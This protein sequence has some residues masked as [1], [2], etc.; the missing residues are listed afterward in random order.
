MSYEKMMKRT[1]GHHHDKDY[2]PM[3]F[4]MN[5]NHIESRKSIAER[6]ADTFHVRVR[7]HSHEE[8]V[9]ISHD[10]LTEDDA[11][12]YCMDNDLDRQYG[13]VRIYTDKGIHL[14]GW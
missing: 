12:Q 5:G 10:F 9:R 1:K 11:V 13:W 7:N 8:F 2:Q 6:T 3:L 4:S 14:S